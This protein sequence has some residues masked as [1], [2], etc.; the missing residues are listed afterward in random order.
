MKFTKIRGER[1]EW[2]IVEKEK[3]RVI[4]VC[5]GWRGPICATY[6]VDALNSYKEELYDK[7]NIKR[8]DDPDENV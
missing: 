8:E 3:N 4:A 7:F 6:I 2:L 5:S 1:G